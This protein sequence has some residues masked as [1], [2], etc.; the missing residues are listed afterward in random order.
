MENLIHG[1][2]AFQANIFRPRRELFERL[3][4]GQRPEVLFITCSDSRIDPNLLTRSEP[5]ELF[6]VRNAG[7]LV[8]PHGAAAGGEAASVEFAVAALRVKD[9]V[10]CGHTD[11]GAMKAL[12]R[13][14]AVRAMPAM[15]AWLAHAEAT[16]R[17][18]RDNHGDLDGD[19]LVTKATEHNVL[20]QLD[21][22]RTLPAVASRLERGDLRLHGWVYDIE[23]GEVY[24][25]DAAGRLFVPVARQHAAHGEPAVR[26]ATAT[27]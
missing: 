27:T 11:C 5:G 19:H 4:K 12:L 6:V 10:V 2:R 16:R 9:V 18:V 14:E 21:N 3:A 25:Y 7:N 17:V 20:A 23:V 26:H 8:P 22:L 1:V 15:A 13:P 24:A